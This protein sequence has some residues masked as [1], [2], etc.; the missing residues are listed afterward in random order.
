MVSKNNGIS[1]L[2]ILVFLTCLKQ[3]ERYLQ[4]MTHLGQYSYV[5]VVSGFGGQTPIAG[6]LSP[7][8]RVIGKN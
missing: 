2:G 7:E 6:N 3:E 8:I 4:P 1:Y 5:V